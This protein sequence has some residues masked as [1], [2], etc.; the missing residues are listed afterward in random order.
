MRQKD[1]NMRKLILLAVT[2]LVMMA[3][4]TSAGGAATAAT[5]P[6]AGDLVAPTTMTAAPLP[7]W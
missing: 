6:S 4:G 2:V 5:D 7:T 1:E 3:G